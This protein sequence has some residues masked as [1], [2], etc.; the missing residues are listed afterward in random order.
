MHTGEDGDLAMS[1]DCA[2]CGATITPGSAFKAPNDRKTPNTVAF[3]NFINKTDYPDLCGKCG[4][5]PVTEAYA[6]VDREIAERTKFIQDRIT[7]FPMFTISW[8]PST[9]DVKLKNMITANVTVG[10]GFF[11]E[12]SQGFSD[13][14]GAV[15]IA[16][17]MSYKVNKGEAAARSILVTKAMSLKANCVVGVD[18]DYGTTLN[19]AATINMQGTAAV[20]LNLDAILHADDLARAQTLHDAY[21]RI[22]QLQRWRTGDLAA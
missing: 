20:V 22:D 6:T 8:L 16:S 11:S 19:N 2:N 18:I 14:T 13:F 21:A 12:F 4:E 15:N 7:D 17:G 3:V 10:T 5:G 1:D 9:A